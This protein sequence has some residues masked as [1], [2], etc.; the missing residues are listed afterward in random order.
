M[1]VSSRLPGRYSSYAMVLIRLLFSY[2]WLESANW[3]N[4]PRFG[5]DT[6][7]DF[8]YWVNNVAQHSHFALGVSFFKTVVMPHFIFFGWLI[9]ILEIALGV[10]FLLGLKTRVFGLVAAV[11]TFSMYLGSFGIPGEWYWS[12]LLMT[13]VGLTLVLHDTSDTV[14]SVDYW[15]KRRAARPPQPATALAE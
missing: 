15:L 4:P 6:G 7:A 10:G 11:F 5:L 8:Y 2:L 9:L 1:M 12:Y 13:M 3:K 14:L